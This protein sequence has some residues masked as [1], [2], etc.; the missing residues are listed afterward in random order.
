LEFFVDKQT[1]GQLAG[2]VAVVTGGSRGIGRAIAIRLVREGALVTVASRTAPVDTNVDALVWHPADVS[3]SNDVES[4]VQTTVSK[5]G[6]IDILVNNA[7]IQIEKSVVET[8]DADWEQLAGVN[9]KGIFLCCR[10]AIRVMQRQHQG[11]IINIGSISATRADSK[12][13]I[14]NASKA[15]VHGLTRSIAVDHGPDG[16]RCNAICPGWIITE[17]ATKVFAQAVDPDQARREAIA[18]HPLGRLG[19]PDDVAA[20]TVWLASDEAAFVTGQCFVV[21]GGLTVASAVVPGRR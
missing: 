4:L 3:R 21:D 16:I 2:K 11:V 18:Q 13:A 5:F 7:G 12:M 6:G 14:Y 10:N 9:M 8:T 20:T 15:F 1:T 19:T 17:M